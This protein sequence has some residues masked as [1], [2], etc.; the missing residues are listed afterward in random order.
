M[1]ER[2]SR[3]SFA[4]ETRER[5]RILGHFVGKEFERAKA[6]EANVFRFEYHTHT[7]SAEFLDNAAVHRLADE[8]VRHQEHIL[9][10]P[11][12]AGQRTDTTW[13]TI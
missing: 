12:D 4:L 5:L 3:F 8:K 10:F 6:M 13:E 7:A 1:V 2:G 9:R 11:P